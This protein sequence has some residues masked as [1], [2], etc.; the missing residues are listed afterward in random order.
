MS[1]NFGQLKTIRRLT[2]T[3]LRWHFTGF[4]VNYLI[5]AP[6]RPRVHNPG[7]EGHGEAAQLPAPLSAG[8]RCD[9]L[10]GAGHAPSLGT[11]RVSQ[12]Q[13]PRLARPTAGSALNTS[14]ELFVT[15]FAGLF[16]EPACI[17]LEHAVQLSGPAWGGTDGM[18][19]GE[20]ARCP[21]DKPEEG[22]LCSR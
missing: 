2:L 18:G 13:R 6:V 14:L 15:G 20:R 16:P 11:D 12:S 8:P 1:P 5:V 3:G 9:R 21:S 4:H 19:S 7:P 17:S 10:A 22:D